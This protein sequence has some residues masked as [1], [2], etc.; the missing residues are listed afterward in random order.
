MQYDLSMTPDQAEALYR[1]SAPEGAEILIVREGD[2]L[3]AGQGD[4]RVRISPAGDTVDHPE[5]YAPGRCEH[6]ALIGFC[7]LGCG[8]EPSG[9]RIA[10]EG[11]AMLAAARDVGYDPAAEDEDGVPIFSEETREEAAQRLEAAG[12]VGEAFQMRHARPEVA[13][14]PR[15]ERDR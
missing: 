5:P 1:W 14:D 11:A 15:G 2:N 9:D 7:T 4:A 13:D 8:A 10:R 6:G 12:H 3:V